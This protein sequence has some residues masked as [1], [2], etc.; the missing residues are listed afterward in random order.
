MNEFNEN[1][2]ENFKEKISEN[3]MLWD[4]LKASRKPIVLYGMGNGAEKILDYCE[5]HGIK[6]SDIFAS[7][8]FVR[9]HSFRGY[10]VK[11]FSEVAEF[12]GDFIILAAF[13]TREKSVIER[14]FALD[15]KYELYAPD[16][17]MFSESNSDTDYFNNFST[18]AESFLQAYNLLADEKSRQ[19]FVNAINFKISGKIKYL[20]EAETPKPEALG[21]LCFEKAQN[22]HYIDVGAYDGDTVF[23]LRSYLSDTGGGNITKITALEPDKKNFAKLCKNLEKANLLDICELYNTAAWNQ[24]QDIC[25]SQKAGRHSAVAVYA[26]QSGR[27]DKINMIQADSIDNIMSDII[28]E[29]QPENRESWRYFIK[30]DVEGCEYEAVTGSAGIIKKYRPALAVSMYHKDED[31]FRMPLLINKINPFY[32]LYLRKHEYIPFWDL[33]LYAL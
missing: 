16:I 14:I 2:I 19:V 21:L 22:I 10:K 18:N 30:Y 33:N 32:K 5:T 23:E 27:A 25:F 29:S 9:G 11:K 7:D 13:A 1:T 15:E 28:A 26:E 31:L 20:R 6:I 12:Y 8:E 24:K 4:K 3:V 17:S